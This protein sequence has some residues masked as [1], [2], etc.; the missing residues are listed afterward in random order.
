MTRS[1]L[2]ADLS[3]KIFLEIA[4]PCGHL[5]RCHGRAHRLYDG[6]SFTATRRSSTLR[7]LGVT[8][9]FW[10]TAI[11]VV[12]VATTLGLGAWQVQRL[13][14]KQGLIENRVT[15]SRAAPLTALPGSFDPAIHAFRRVEVKGRFLHD[16]ELYLGARSMNGN[17]GFH[18]MTPLRLADGS[19]L[20]VNRGW[21]PSSLKTPAL[22]AAGQLT[23]EVTVR[24]YLRGDQKQAWFTRDNNPAVNMWY[25]VDVPA[26]A[27]A[28]GLKGVRP[29][30]VEAA[31]ADIP[32]GYPLGG[33][34]RL[35]LHNDHLQYAITWFSIA[36]A[37]MVIWYLWHRRREREDGAADSSA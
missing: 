25:F 34:T 32:G 21:I 17:L 7:I 5:G 15:K 26:M 4:I 30:Y 1:A 3:R 28:S 27:A 11:T 37:G 22:R 10:P 9:R 29:Y 12:A 24:G 18:V 36:I 31:R 23:G 16:K 2:Q 6:G 35:T 14:W 13:F 19:H 20:L 33:Q 8:P